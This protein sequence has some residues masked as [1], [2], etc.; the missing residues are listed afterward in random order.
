MTNLR[1]CP[2]ELMSGVMDGELTASDVSE[3]GASDSFMLGY[4]TWLSSALL[5]YSLE[6]V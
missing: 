5:Y 6:E 3:L 4:T 1:T 2:Y